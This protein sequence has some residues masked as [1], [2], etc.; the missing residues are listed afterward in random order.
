M[1]VI[2][3]YIYVMES[4]VDTRKIFKEY[5]D[6]KLAYDLLENKTSK[7]ILKLERDITKTKDKL[8]KALEMLSKQQESVVNP[9][10]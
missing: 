10:I 1:Q 3:W 5:H 4:G 6:L 2:N 9:L 8:K 7:K